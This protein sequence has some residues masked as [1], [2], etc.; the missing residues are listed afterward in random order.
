MVRIVTPICQGVVAHREEGCARVWSAGALQP[1]HSDSGDDSDD[2]DDDDDEDDEALQASLLARGT[3]S[4]GSDL[5]ASRPHGPSPG[6]PAAAARATHRALKAVGPDFPLG[7]V[8][9]S[10]SHLPSPNVRFSSPRQ[11]TAH[12]PRGVA[13]VLIK[14]P[15]GQLA[16]RGRL[17]SKRSFSCSVGAS[18]GPDAFP[19][20]PRICA[21]QNTLPGTRLGSTAWRKHEAS[22]LAHE[23]LPL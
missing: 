20:P 19:S 12:E 5:R 7:A 4:P 21:L 1:R 10:P 3:P 15:A 2:G 11:H 8:S 18:C 16:L 9:P 22:L 6:P 14:Y 17:T 13:T 23:K